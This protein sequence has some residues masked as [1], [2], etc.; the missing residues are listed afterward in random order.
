[1][2]KYFGHYAY[3]DTRTLKSIKTYMEAY[4]AEEKAKDR[5]DL[6]LLRSINRR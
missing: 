6:E 5:H 3:I 2:E 4:I 1:M